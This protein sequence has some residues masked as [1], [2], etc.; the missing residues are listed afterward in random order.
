MAAVWSEPHRSRCIGSLPT[1]PTAA[2][3]RRREKTMGTEAHARRRGSYGIDAPYL[4]AVPLLLIV[5]G[6]AQGVLTRNV[7][8][9]VGAALVMAFSGFGLYA[10]R[11]G[12]FVVWDRLFDQLNLT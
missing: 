1:R 4:L 6:L 3:T 10:S 5:S 9:F 8:P 2:A 12:K 7:W 11:R